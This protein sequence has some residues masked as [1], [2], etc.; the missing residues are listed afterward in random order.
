MSCWSFEWKKKTDQIHQS[1]FGLVFSDLKH[2]DK[3]ID[4]L[5]WNALKIKYCKP[6]L[7]FC[8]VTN[9]ISD[10]IRFSE[11]LNYLFHFLNIALSVESLWGQVSRFELFKENLVMMT[12]LHNLTLRN[13]L[14]YFCNGLE[15]FWLIGTLEISML[16]TI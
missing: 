1:N 11:L 9:F 13:L 7:E 15:K 2:F 8:Y 4:G 12:R 3:F 10:S 14:S 5:L 16:F 6:F